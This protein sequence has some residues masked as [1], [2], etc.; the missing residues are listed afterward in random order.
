M[1]AH[2]SIALG[3]LR[4]KLLLLPAAAGPVSVDI[5]EGL[6]V[7]LYVLIVGLIAYAVV[8]YF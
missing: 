5:I 7:A 3:E 6:V 4:G 8:R 2:G 1:S